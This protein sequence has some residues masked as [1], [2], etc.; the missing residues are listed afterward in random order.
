MRVSVSACP[1]ALSKGDCCQKETTLMAGMK[2]TTYI[3]LKLL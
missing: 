3:L 1:E 2:V